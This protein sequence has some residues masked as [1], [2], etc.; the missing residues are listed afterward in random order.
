MEKLSSG[1]YRSLAPWVGTFNTKL[2]NPKLQDMGVGAS[3]EKKVPHTGLYTAEMA[4]T[5]PA[6][7]SGSSLKQQFS[8]M[9]GASLQACAD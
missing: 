8:L 9:K 3:Q 5:V 6:Q 4:D 2:G 1:I 7:H